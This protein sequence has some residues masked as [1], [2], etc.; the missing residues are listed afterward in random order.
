MFKISRVYLRVPLTPMIQSSAYLKFRSLMKFGFLKFI[1]LCFLAY[2]LKSCTSFRFP[3]VFAL[4]I[5]PSY[6]IAT[7]FLCGFSPLS[8]F[9]F[10]EVINSSS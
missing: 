3:L 6:Y 2:R 1:K 9:L 8:K 7:R 4:E 5:F 10:R